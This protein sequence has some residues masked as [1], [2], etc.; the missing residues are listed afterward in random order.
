ML[1]KLNAIAPI[2]HKIADD[3]DMMNISRQSAQR[4]LRTL[5]GPGK[6][7]QTPAQP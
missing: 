6:P 1:R 3:P 4:L 2:L 5:N 7:S